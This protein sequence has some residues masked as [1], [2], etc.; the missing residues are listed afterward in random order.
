MVPPRANT[1]IRAAG[2]GEMVIDGIAYWLA[3]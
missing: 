3:Q 2:A 1:A